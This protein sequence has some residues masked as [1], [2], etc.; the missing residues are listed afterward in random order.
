MDPKTEVTLIAPAKVGGKFRAVGA[1]I[2]VDATE[3]EHLKKAGAVPDDKSIVAQAEQADAPD[4]LMAQLAAAVDEQALAIVELEAELGELATLLG[5]T[6]A[7]AVEAEA[8]RDMLQDRV[9]ELQKDVGEAVLRAEAAEAGKTN[10]PPASP[11]VAPAK[12]KKASASS[13]KA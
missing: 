4:A 7:R 1:V 13:S 11:E 2:D 8:Q 12:P 3:L 10:E 5:A 6:E 9:V